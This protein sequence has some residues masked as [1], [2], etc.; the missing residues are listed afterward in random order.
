MFDFNG[1]VVLIM[2]V[3]WGIGEVGVCSFVKYGVKVVL[4]V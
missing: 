4:V 1:C 3:S 2:G